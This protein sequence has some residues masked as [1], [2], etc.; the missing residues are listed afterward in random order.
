MPNVIVHYDNG[1]SFDSPHL[2]VWYAGSPT[3]HDV[4]ATRHDAWG[5]VFEFE[6]LQPAFSLKFKEGPGTNG[7]WEDGSVERTHQGGNDEL[8]CVADNA[9]VYGVEPRTVESQSAEVYLAQLPS[10]QGTDPGRR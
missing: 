7:P 2:W 9:F 3:S 6:A 10:R 8:W 5:A 1:R 4:S